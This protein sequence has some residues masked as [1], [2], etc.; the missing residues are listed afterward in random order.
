MVLFWSGI[1][2]DSIFMHFSQ[3]IFYVKSR[4]CYQRY[5]QWT[6]LRDSS[7]WQNSESPGQEKVTRLCA[8]L[9]L[10]ELLT[11]APR[12]VRPL[13]CSIL[14]EM[15]YWM[16]CTFLFNATLDPS[17]PPFHIRSFCF[18]GLSGWG[19]VSPNQECTFS[20]EVNT[21]WGVM[22]TQLPS[23]LWPLI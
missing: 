15:I 17:P 10:F 23:P 21:S 1:E 7:K 9:D 22:G 18:I 6:Q 14:V 4:T 8:A 19:R 12:M 5:S 16:L 2:L 11:D 13:F 20:E 3:R